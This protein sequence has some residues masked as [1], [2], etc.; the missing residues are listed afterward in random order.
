MK[1]FGK[2]TV[3]ALL[4]AVSGIGMTAAQD[5]GAKQP[6]ASAASSSDSAGPVFTN[7]EQMPAFPG[8]DAALFG[9]VARNLKYPAIAVE[10]NIQGTVIVQFVVEKDGSVGEVKVVKS[11][12]YNLDKEAVRVCKILPKFTPGKQNGQPVR[13]YYTM[14]VTFRLQ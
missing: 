7:V 12:D 4:L 1:L 8:G 14:P 6:A 9:F 10:S 13:V 5:I 2:S 3:V 11:V